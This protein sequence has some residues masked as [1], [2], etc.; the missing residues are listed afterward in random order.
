VAW[1]QEGRLLA[2]GNYVDGLPSGQWTLWWGTEP[3]RKRREGVYVD[4]QPDGVWHAWMDPGHVHAGH[5]T[6]TGHGHDQP[7]PTAGNPDLAH[8][9][10]QVEESYR[11]GTP[12]GPWRS[13]H[14]DGGLADSCFYVEGHLEGLVISYHPNRRKALEAFYRNGEQVGRQTVWNEAGEVVAESE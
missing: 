12:H 3:N 8:P 6:H 7:A 10:P 9:P 14:Q 4:G 5:G 11:M 13:W 1:N 2:E